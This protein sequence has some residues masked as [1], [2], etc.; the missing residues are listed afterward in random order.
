VSRYLIFTALLVLTPSVSA[1][2]EFPKPKPSPAPAPVVEDSGQDLGPLNRKDRPSHFAD[3]SGRAVAV[4]MEFEQE[5]VHDEKVLRDYVKRLR[6]FGLEQPRTLSLSALHAEFLPNVELAS[7]LLAY[8]GMPED[9]AALV[10]SASVVGDT[11]IAGKCLDAAIALHSGVLPAHSIRLLAHPRKAL[12]A[13]VE[14]RLVAA[15]HAEHQAEF[16][17]LLRSGRDGDTRLRCARLLKP[18]LEHEEVLGALTTAL[19]DAAVPVA[20]QAANILVAQPQVRGTLLSSLEELDG[21]G[22][23]LFEVLKLQETSQELLIDRDLLPKLRD[24]FVSPDPFISGTAA[25]GLAE[26]HFRSISAKGAGVSDEELLHTLVRSVAG[27][28]YFP[29][30]SR[31]APVG[32]NS[33]KRITGEDLSHRERRAWLAW[34]LENLEGF[35]AVRG[36]LVLAEEDLPNLEVRWKSGEEQAR[37]LAGGAVAADTSGQLRWLGAQGL[38]HLVGVLEDARLLDVRVLPGSYG[39]LESPVTARVEVIVGSQRKPLLFRGDSGAVWLP[40]LF[41][42][43]DALFEQNLWQ[44]IA[45]AGGAREFVQ[46]R[47][48][49]WDGSDALSRMRFELNLTNERIAGLSHQELSD[50]VRHL[51]AQEENQALWDLELALRFLAEIPLRVEDERLAMDLQELALR[52]PDPSLSAPLVES[53]VDLEE[54]LRSGLLLSGLRRLGPKVAEDGLQNERLV[55]RVAAARALGSAGVAGKEALL[56]AT[57]DPN[58][59]VV[60]MAIRSLG[61]LGDADLAPVLLGFATPQTAL[62]VRREAVAALGH[63]GHADVRDAIELA[64]AAS[65][66]SSLRSIAVEALSGLDPKVAMLSYSKVWPDF[67]GG[68]L[69]GAFRRSLD[70]MGCEVAVAALTPHLDAPVLSVAHL[71]A[72]ALGRLGE[73]DAVPLLME[74]LRESPQDFE[75]QAVLASAS[76]TDFRDMPDPAGVWAAWWR[77]NSLVDSTAWLEKAAANYGYPLPANHTMDSVVALEDSVPVLLNLVENGPSHLRAP[78]S[79]SLASLSGIHGPVLTEGLAADRVRAGLLVWKDWWRA[80][81]DA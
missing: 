49:A 1:Q 22:Y 39:D 19:K 2:I 7:Q 25:A 56:K 73:G 32:E 66:D 21:F 46:E 45:P 74:Q 47:L 63:L 38:R 60:R 76:A 55:V 53:V 5:E 15:P 62:A 26:Y 52:R 30:F 54:P 41:D 77:E 65:E 61:D 50:W 28:T 59:L 8:V 10:D 4:W 81:R 79:R 80:K 34:E 23:L 43:L 78:A 69:E 67:A 71:T 42:E 35:T 58:A 27:T 75:L 68:P 70:K 31:F 16:M 11:R 12:R 37:V 24:F 3:Q 29:Q 51:L 14:K 40:A 9:A 57:T 72:R 13:V 33:L 36:T 6:G 64:C 20:F 18:Y 17:R 44:S 48:S